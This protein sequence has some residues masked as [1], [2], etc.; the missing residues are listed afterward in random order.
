MKILH[1]VLQ[2]HKIKMN[3][4]IC[5]MKN[6]LARTDWLRLCV[7]VING[8]RRHRISQ[9][10]YFIC[11]KSAISYRFYFLYLL[12]Q[13]LID[14]FFPSFFLDRNFWKILENVRWAI[15]KVR[16]WIIHVIQCSVDNHIHFPIAV[17]PNW[18]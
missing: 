3:E 14:S 8:F 9:L 16:I 6:M 15:R 18:L 12:K 1:F 7:I 2:I 11:L 5:K 10:Y 17:I 13:K 4:W